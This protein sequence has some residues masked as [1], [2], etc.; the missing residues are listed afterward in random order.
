MS[1]PDL[2]TEEERLELELAEQ[3]RLNSGDWDSVKPGKAANFGKSFAR[4]IGVN[5]SAKTTYNGIDTSTT[6]VSVTLYHSITTKNT[7]ENN[8]SNTSVK[9]LPVRKVRMFSSSRMRATE[10][11]TRLASK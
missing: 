5:T 1:T 6:I 7:I 3:A 2:I 8:T 10:S 4:M 11:P 9:A